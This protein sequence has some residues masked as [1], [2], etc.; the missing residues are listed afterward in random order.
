MSAI[1][2]LVLNDGQAAPVAKTFTPM[3]CTSALATW[4]DRT[5][6]IALG[7][8]QVTLSLVTGKE[9]VKVTGKVA[10]P[11]M[12]VISGS[13][14]GYTP[15]PKVAYTVLSKFEMVLPNRSS[16]QNRKDVSAFLKNLLADAVVTK[17]VEEFERPY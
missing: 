10:L 4:S 13:D 11:V 9:A 8:P 14:G 15:S 7:M 17:A 16:L 12:E 1:A 3:D 6:G 5:S 2:A